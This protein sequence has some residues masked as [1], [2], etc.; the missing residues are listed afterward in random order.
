MILK[1]SNSGRCDDFYSCLIVLDIMLTVAILFHLL[2]CS[3][4]DATILACIAF[5]C[6]NLKTMEI[7]MS[8]SPVNRI[9]G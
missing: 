4:L 9:T 8:K 2:C 1:F 5:S 6:Y 7:T 3:D